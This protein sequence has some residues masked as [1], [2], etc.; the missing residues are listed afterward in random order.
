[1]SRI[2]PESQH[3][4]RH[5]GLIVSAVKSHNSIGGFRATFVDALEAKY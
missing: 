1:M 2:V 3:R 5:S 4:E